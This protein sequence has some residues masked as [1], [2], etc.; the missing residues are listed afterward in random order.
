MNC[1]KM[2]KAVV[3]VPVHAVERLQCSSLCGRPN[4]PRYRSCTFVCPS[5]RVPSSKTKWLRKP[6]FVWTFPRAC[7][8]DVP[9]FSPRTWNDLPD[10]VTSAESL[11]T[12]RQRLKTHLFTKSFFWWFPGLDSIS[13]LSSRSGPSSGF[14]YLG[15]FKNP[16]LID[17]LIDWL[18]D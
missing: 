10:D 6:K 3:I 7:V 16:G 8:T 18:I 14:C 12:L 15:H 9:L 2:V 11:S 5:V 4:R 1:N 13:P 17:W